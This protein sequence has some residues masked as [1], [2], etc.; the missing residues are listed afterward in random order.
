MQGSLGERIAAFFLGGHPRLK[1]EE[2]VHNPGDRF[3]LQ[4][5]ATGV[6]HLQ[7]GGQG[8]WGWG[9]T[10]VVLCCAVPAVLASQAREG[11]GME[12]AGREAGRRGV[13]RMG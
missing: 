1:L 11:A 10:F 3:R 8:R 2:V 12:R 4:T 6:V 5:D 13:Q 9:L 7:I